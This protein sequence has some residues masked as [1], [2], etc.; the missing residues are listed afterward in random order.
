MI[1]AYL[2]ALNTTLR[3]PR[4]AKTDLLTEA[5]DHLVDATET[6]ERNG[7]DRPAAEQ[8]AIEDFGDLDEIAPGYQAELSLAQG[9]RTA[10]AAL[11]LTAAQPLVW[12]YTFPNTP[13]PPQLAD[14]IVE[15]VGG[16]VILLTLLAVLTYRW[17]MRHPA[18][19]ENLAQLTGVGALGVCA[20]LISASTLLTAWSNNHLAPLWTVIF[21]LAPAAWVATSARRCLLTSRPQHATD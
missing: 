6:H 3:G 8:A 13:A 9:H 10:L 16:V 12:N 2:E 21:V 17:G 20:F 18:T 11:S 15:N 7:L 14:N 4:R 19:R 1:D 5:R